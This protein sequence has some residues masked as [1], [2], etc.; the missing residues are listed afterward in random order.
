M[1]KF[2]KKSNNTDEDPGSSESLACVSIKKNKYKKA[3]H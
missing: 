1:L 2:L 3:Y